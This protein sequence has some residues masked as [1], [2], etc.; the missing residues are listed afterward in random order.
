MGDWFFWWQTNSARYENVK[1]ALYHRLGSSPLF[2]TQGA[3]APRMSARVT[4]RGARNV[5][6][7]AL[8]RVLEKDPKDSHVRAAALLALGKLGWTSEHGRVL[9]RSLLTARD[10]QVGEAA[11]L[12]LGLLRRAEPEDQLPPHLLLGVREALFTAVEAPPERVSPRVK[13]A[14][15]LALGL[16]GDQPVACPEGEDVDAVRRAHTARL[17]AAFQAVLGDPDPPDPPDRPDR[18]ASLA[19]ALGHQIP[20]SFSAAQRAELE[21]IVRDRRGHE[22]TQAWTAFALGRIGDAGSLDALLDSLGTGRAVDRNS[23]RAAVAAVSCLARSGR[24]GDEDRGRAIEALRRVSGASPGTLVRG[25]A[26]VGLGELGAKHAHL[27]ARLTAAE[28]A[29]RDRAFAALAVGLAARKIHEAVTPEVLL[30]WRSNALAVLREIVEDR[31]SPHP[32]LRA[33]CCLALGLARD[34][35]ARASLLSLL[36]AEDPYGQL[37]GSAAWGLGLLG[38]PTPETIRA[39][40]RAAKSPEPELRRR[41]VRGLALLGNPWIPGT[42][43]DLVSLLLADLEEAQAFDRR[44]DTLVLLARFGDDRAFAPLAAILEDADVA[45]LHRALA[46]SALGA[47][48]DLE[49]LSAFDRL[50][51]DA[52]YFASTDVLRRA[53]RYL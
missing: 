16:L 26:L 49:W 44:R 12:G 48:G 30:A 10:A 18:A 38:R 47:V 13:G 1:W 9:V 43:D 14:A 15:A 24:L 27:L 23:A 32:R 17:F 19:L 35:D 3:S 28:D 21:A 37:A 2:L 51:A 5:A 40:A 53:F 4:A 25:L 29:E 36:D 34:G 7:P 39:L 20:D 46:A 6:L 41:S 52:N 22:A 11:A 33:A 50:R 45:S 42:R 31:E 8:L